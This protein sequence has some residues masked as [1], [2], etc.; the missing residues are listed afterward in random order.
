MGLPGPSHRPGIREGPTST[1]AL[2]GCDA[3]FA[4]R[5]DRP[6]SARDPSRYPSAPKRTA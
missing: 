6:A 5:V 1:M 4:L 2:S 3:E